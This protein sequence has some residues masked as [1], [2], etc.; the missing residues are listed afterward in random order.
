MYTKLTA[1]ELDALKAIIQ[2]KQ[3]PRTLASLDIGVS[4]PTLNNM[5]GPKRKGDF[6]TNSGIART[7]RLYLTRNGCSC[8]E[9]GKVVDDIIR[10]AVNRTKRAKA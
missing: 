6:G 5:I 7:V 1:S 2:Q 10:R 3:L 4:L 9:G 8:G